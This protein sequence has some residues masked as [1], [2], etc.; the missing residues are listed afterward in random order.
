MDPRDQPSRPARRP[1]GFVAK[2]PR[3]AGTRGDPTLD[4]AEGEERSLLTGDFQLFQLVRGHRWSMD[5][6][7]TAYIARES[8]LARWPDAVGDDATRSLACLDMGCGIGSVLLMCAWSLPRSHC[9]GIEAQ[10][11][12]ASM[13]RRSARFNGVDDRVRVLDGDLRDP[14]VLTS[15]IA[16]SPAPRFDLVTGTPPYFRDGEGVESTVDQRGPCRFEHRGGVEDYAL[17]AARYLSDDGVAV[18]C[19]GSL[20]RDRAAAGIAASGLDLIR[21]VEVVPRAFKA[22]LVD[23]YV[24]ARRAS[25]PSTVERETLVVRGLDEQWTPAFVALRDAMGIPSAPPK[26]R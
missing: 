18:L 23:V 26:R 7:V 6:L 13:A 5:D 8:A 4:P 11:R 25:A 17:S 15:E 16:D 22:P 10:P 14:S 12:S 9:T 21:W 20:E 24:L 1:E 2:G 19:A 3:P